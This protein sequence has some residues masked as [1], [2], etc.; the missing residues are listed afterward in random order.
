MANLGNLYYSVQ[1]KDLT[2]KQIKEIRDKLETLDFRVDAHLNFDKAAFRKSMTDFL[3]Q[4]VFKAR[5]DVSE[6][7]RE[8]IRKA[9]QSVTVRNNTSPGD[10]RAQRILEIQE[11]M[12]QRAALSQEK[13]RLAQIRTTSA[14]ER[15]RSSSSG[16]NQTFRSQSSIVGQLGNQLSDVFSIYSLERFAGRLIEIGGQFQTQHI[17]LKA[18]LGDAAKADAIFGKIKGLAVESPYTFMDLASYTKQLTAF[19]IPYNEL[20]DTTKRLSDI[21]AGLGVDMGRIILAY[22]QVRSAAFLRG[23]EV[24]QFTEAGIPLLDALAKKFTELEGRVVSVGEVFDKISSREVPFEMV[25]EVLWDM[26]N[27]GGQFFNMQAQ[28]VDSLSGKYDKLKDSLQIMLSE[29]ADSSNDVLGGGLDLLTSFT[30]RWEDLGQVLISVGTGFGMYKATLLVLNAITAV[31]VVRKKS[32]ST[33]VQIATKS[34]AGETLAMA[35]VNTQSARMISGVN[36]LKTAFMGLG[37]G[38]WAGIIVGALSALGMYLYSAYQRANR[39]K[40]EL[41]EIDSEAGVNEMNLIAGYKKLVREL[42]EATVGTEAY[43]D[44]IKQIN[45]SYGQYL[46]QLYSEAEAYDRVKESVDSVTQAIINKS[47]QQAYEKKVSAIEDDYAERLQ[48]AEDDLSRTIKTLYGRLDKETADNMADALTSLLRGGKSVDQAFGLVLDDYRGAVEKALGRK[49]EVK[50]FR[51]VNTTDNNKNRFFGDLINYS[52]LLKSMN[53]ELDKAA[54]SQTGYT[55]Y[56]NQL[57]EIREKWEEI[58]KNSTLTADEKRLNLIEMYRE[59]LELLDRKNVSNE[60]PV[61]KNIETQISALEQLDKEWV[62]TTNSI[63]GQGTKLSLTDAYISNPVSYLEMLAEEY[64]KAKEKIGQNGL[65]G[66]M[67]GDDNVVK[68]NLDKAEETVARIEELG[69]KLGVDIGAFGEKESGEKKDPVAEAWKRHIELL[70]DAASEYDKFSKKYGKNTAQEKLSG[71]RSFSDLGKGFDFSRSKDALRDFVNKITKEARG[72]Q[73]QDVVA[74]GLR[75]LLEFEYD[76]DSLERVRKDIEKTIDNWDIYKKLFDATG[77]KTLSE[78]LAFTDIQVWDE[79]AEALRKDLFYKMGTLNLSQEENLFSKTEEEAR[80]FFGTNGELFELWKAIKKRIEE[81]GVNLKINTADALANAQGLTNKIAI[82]KAE[83]AEALRGVKEGT[84][85]Y[86]AISAA[87]DSQ[88]SD[89]EAQAF[90]ASDAFK[91]FFTG[92]ADY[93][94]IALLRLRDEVRRLL[95]LIED[96]DLIKDEYGNVTGYKFTDKGGKQQTIST[97]GVEKLKNFLNSNGLNGVLRVADKIKDAFS[98]EGMAAAEAFGEAAS[99]IF[100][101]GAEISNGIGSFFSAFGND[102]AAAKAELAGGIFTGLSNMADFTNPASIIKGITGIITSVAQFHDNKLQKEIEESE[103]EVK[104]LQNAYKNLQSTIENQLGSV[105]QE[106]AREMQ[107]N[108]H[109]QS[110]EMKKQMELEEEKSNTDE[111]KLEDM[112]QQYQEALEAERN[113]TK[114]LAES[115]Y[116]VNLK[117]WASQIA[118]ALVEA[119]AAGED[120]AKAFDDTVAEIMKSVISEM[121]SLKVIEPAMERLQNTLFGKGGIFDENSEG[122]TDLTENEAVILGDSLADLRDKVNDSKEIWDHISEALKGVGINME[123]LENENTLTKGIENVTE[124]TASLLASY[125]NAMRADVSANRLTLERLMNEYV[126]QMSVI[127]QAQLTQL[128]AIADNTSRNA[129]FAAEIRDILLRNING[130]NLFHIK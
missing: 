5:I 65:L 125:I 84:P 124:D 19:S 119:F 111:E 2:D 82:K 128:N 80:D 126:P 123:D 116:G 115:Q 76:D 3:S 47:R 31:A 7:V 35:A 79:A 63:M 17:A 67:I 101:A 74:E 95:R 41:A 59:Q 24:R 110:E 78:K 127:A 36:R 86:N 72:D 25:K 21:S 77:D 75:V 105:T 83:K 85:E 68:K 28:L 51:I 54:R 57:D 9:S 40:N 29:I 14:S 18:M 69:K 15:L 11:R 50:D 45:S 109:Q 61:Y 60:D 10:V 16:L 8:S 90:E 32:F 1:L 129:D 62:K 23:Q 48:D 89:L 4:N 27:E 107:G 43:S 104:K 96:G 52:N 106:Q 113:F 92:A 71:S 121:I 88:I 91:Q 6:S 99:E 46:D 39:L 130:G 33:A 103:F 93:G 56:G 22:G 44:I 112:K 38:G 117:D 120:A 114:E 64:A 34:L 87:Y 66:G 49:L 20:Y 53:S 73:Q 26:T 58:N 13:L 12:A 81:N 98:K 97:T 30:D 102:E 100:N 37:K 70:K 42:G 94:G 118:N 55:I 122:G 108:L